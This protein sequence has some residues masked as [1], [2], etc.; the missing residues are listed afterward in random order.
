MISTDGLNQHRSILGYRKWLNQH[1][2]I[3]I[4]GKQSN[5]H[6]GY[7]WT[8]VCLQRLFWRYIFCSN[9]TGLHRNISEKLRFI[10]YKKYS[11][12]KVFHASL[13]SSVVEHWSRKPGVVSSNL[14]GGINFSKQKDFFKHFQIR[15]NVLL[16]GFL[17]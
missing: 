14:T 5:R 11:Y 8:S 7:F 9:N 2:D 17:K 15:K 3:L 16:R 4:Q 1:R 13:H 10:I 12:N 6:R